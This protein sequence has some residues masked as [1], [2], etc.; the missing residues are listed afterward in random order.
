MKNIVLIHYYPY[1]YLNHTR[2]IIEKIDPTIYFRISS[3]PKF[4]AYLIIVLK[5]KYDLRRL[6]VI[7]LFR[8][9]QAYL[10]IIF[11]QRSLELLSFTV[12]Y[13]CLIRLFRP[14]YY[15]IA[16]IEKLPSLYIYDIKVF[17]MV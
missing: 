2:F 9:L 8:Y 6:I 14:I 16:Y 4:L 7:I 11:W 1:T 3:A 12:Y 15:L 13:L 5:P 17:L 10:C